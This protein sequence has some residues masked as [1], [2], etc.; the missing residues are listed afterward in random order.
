MKQLRKQTWRKKCFVA[1]CIILSLA[2]ASTAVV[3]AVAKLTKTV[4]NRFTS[5]EIT[6]AVVENGDDNSDPEAATELTWE[7][8]S[9]SY[10][11]DKEVQIKN[12]NEDDVNNADAYIRVAL[13]PSYNAAVEVSTLSSVDVEVITPSYSLK[14]FGELT[15]I[16]I[17]GNQ[18]TMGDVTFTLADDWDDYW[19]WNVTDG[20][21]YYKAI[22]SPGTTTEPLLKSV[23]ISRDVYSILIAN[24]IE[25]EVDVIADSIQTLGGAVDARW[26][27]ADISIGS[28][29]TLT[30]TAGGG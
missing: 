6:I 30:T 2:L 10:T 25:L 1:I 13:I 9:G 21:F 17:S 26:S 3:Y 4:S 23:S 27:D 20:Y 24:D 29:G 22:V 7:Q 14:S 19:F 12:V 11:A 5:D 28:D 15:D 18:F 8:D 16:S